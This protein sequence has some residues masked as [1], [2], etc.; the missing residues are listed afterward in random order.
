MK[1]TFDPEAI[2]N[3]IHR[4]G[5]VSKITVSTI[6]AQRMTD[7]LHQNKDNT[8]DH[9]FDFNYRSLVDKEIIGVLWGRD[10]HIDDDLPD[11]ILVLTVDGSSIN[12][13]AE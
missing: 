10:V 6:L 11:D 8:F 13:Q 1:I 3:A 2:A 4:A 5:N 12:Y 7:G 9:Y